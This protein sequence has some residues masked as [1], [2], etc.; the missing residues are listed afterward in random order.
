MTTEQLAPSD[1][2]AKAVILLH[3]L[4][5][6]SSAM[7][8]LQRRFRNQGYRTLI[9]GYRSFFQS[10]EQIAAKTILRCQQ[11]HDALPDDCELS[12]VG[13]SLGAILTRYLLQQRNFPKLRRVVLI[14]P[15]NQG[16]HVA[17][18][19]GKVC[20]PFLP[21]VEE[22]ADSPDSFV[23][24]MSQQMPVETGVIASAPDYLID[25]SCTHISSETDFTTL[26]GP[27]GIVI[28]RKSV[29]EETLHFLEQGRFSRQKES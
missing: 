28:F 11:F 2:P 1:H 8:V 26:P 17:R 3:G 14:T 13:H 16:S 9:C 22:L 18:R 24:R 20:K 15:P 5:N 27:H 19:M 21:V 12:I 25:A 4:L 23:N 10:I 7:W 29:F 6:P